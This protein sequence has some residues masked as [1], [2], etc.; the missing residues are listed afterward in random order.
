MAAYHF[1]FSTIPDRSI[2]IQ[3]SG[4][5][6]IASCASCSLCLYSEHFERILWFNSDRLVLVTKNNFHKRALP[7]AFSGQ[8]RLGRR[9][10]QEQQRMAAR[11]NR[12]MARVFGAFKPTKMSKDSVSLAFGSFGYLAWSCFC[13]IAGLIRGFVANTLQKCRQV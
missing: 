8:R 5:W 2:F 12:R 9:Q 6:S 7:G 11:K 3:S 13:V 4:F 10:L 1:E